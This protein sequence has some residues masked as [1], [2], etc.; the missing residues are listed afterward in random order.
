MH[1][2]TVGFPRRKSRLK[3]HATGRGS[4]RIATYCLAA[5]DHDMAE[6]LCWHTQSCPEIVA[7]SL[8]AVAGHG[9]VCMHTLL[10]S[11]PSGAGRPSNLLLGGGCVSG[12]AREVRSLSAF[13]GGGAASEHAARWRLVEMVGDEREALDRRRCLGGKMIWHFPKSMSRS[14]VSVVR[15][16]VGWLF[17][18]FG[19][20]WFWV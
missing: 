4:F 15:I 10:Q 13:L 16:V 5:L 18:W 11:H 8:A 3:A 20:R 17:V 2:R 7:W 6:I 19:L 9:L 12:M 1:N 14:R